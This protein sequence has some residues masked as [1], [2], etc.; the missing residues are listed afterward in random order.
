MSVKCYRI[1]QVGV[2]GLGPQ[3]DSHSPAAMPTIQEELPAAHTTDVDTV[4]VN[5]NVTNN[6]REDAPSTDRSD[7]EFLKRVEEEVFGGDAQEIEPK[8]QI[9]QEMPNDLDLFDLDPK[10]GECTYYNCSF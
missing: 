2:N 6:N 5:L 1:G 9:N 10:D 3:E 7:E 4:G 8:S